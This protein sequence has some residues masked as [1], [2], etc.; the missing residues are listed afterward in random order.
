MSSSPHLLLLAGSGEAR[1]IASALAQVPLRV[2]ASV[3]EP[4]HWSGPLPVPMRSGGFGGDQGFETYLQDNV[5]TAVLD[6]THP[7]AARVSARSWD[8]CQKLGVPF[9]QVDR[10]PWSPGPADQW[11][12]VK[13]EAEAIALVPSGAR[14]FVTTGRQ[15]LPAARAATDRMFFFRLLRDAPDGAEAD[16]I[17][18]VS[19][20]GPFSVAHE[21][22][23]FRDLRIDVLVCKN[24]GG[25]V[26]ATKLEA[27][28][29]LNLPVILLRRPPPTG[30]PRLET[31]EAALEWVRAT[32]Q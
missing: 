31:V 12:E 28:R 10:P 2:T 9:A 27:A 6:A 16:H 4:D 29:A 22:A 21:E 25:S 15:A 5:V 23:L 14:A 30:A 32:C 17:S 8:V 18:F 26:S 20:A 11:T 13:T 7:F 3:M 24:A 1:V 19:G